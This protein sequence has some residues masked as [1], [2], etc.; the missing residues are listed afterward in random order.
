MSSIDNIRMSL[1]NTHI[2]TKKNQKMKKKRTLTHILFNRMVYIHCCWL[3]I[4]F[5]RREFFTFQVEEEEE[6]EN[7]ENSKWNDFY[8]LIRSF[9]CLLVLLLMMMIFFLFSSFTFNFHS[10]F[11]FTMPL[12]SNISINTFTRVCVCVLYCLNS[13]GCPKLIVYQTFS[14]SLSLS[15]SFS[16]S[17]LIQ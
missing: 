17:L 5:V 2:Y 11:T 10:K 6:K 4:E 16:R 15:A 9:V 8:S 1:A 13:I 12:L 7:E 3:F 14:L